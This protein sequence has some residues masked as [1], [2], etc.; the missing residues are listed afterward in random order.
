MLRVAALALL[1]ALGMQAHAATTVSFEPANP[2]PA[3]R[4]VVT[5]RDSSP[6]CPNILPLRT[7]FLPPDQIRLEYSHAFDCGLAPFSETK[8]TL[9]PLPMGTY[10]VTV[11]R[12]TSDI[13]PAPPPETTK[14]LVVNPPA[15]TGGPTAAG[16]LENYAGHYLI[17]PY[18]GEGVFIEQHG[19]KSFLT[20]ATYDSQGRPTWFVMPDARWTYNAARSRFE[21]AGALY[22]TLRGEESPPSI[23]VTPIG[24]GAWYPTG[25]DTVVLE[26][27]IENFPMARLRRYR[28]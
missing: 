18:S 5:I 26:T 13:S 6:T 17:G 28:F 4:I 19:A 9:G 27:T 15:G 16:P 10:T 8:T 7:L 20:Y 1:A 11:G 12:N 24:T 14:Q 22:R 25:F 3:D 23:R 2:T 21:F